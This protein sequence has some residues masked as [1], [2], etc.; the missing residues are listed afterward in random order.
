MERLKVHYHVFE[1]ADGREGWQ[2]TLSIHPTL[3]I[4][5]VAMPNVDGIEFS[6]KVKSDK[7]TSHIPLILLTAS[8]GD[9]QQLRGLL[10]GANDYLTKPFN[11]EI[12]NAKVNNLLALNRVSKGYYSKRINLVKPEVEIE[13]GN[14]KLLKDIAFFIE[15]N[16][17]NSLLSVENLSKHVGM[18]RGTLYSR[19]LELTGK[20]PVEYIRSVK[21]E[22]S[23]MLLEKSDLNISQIAY[24]VGFPNANYF[25]K[26]FKSQFNMLPSEYRNAKHL[27]NEV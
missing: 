11:F 24:S 22:K 25:T 8:T 17:N 12:L 6:Q 10:S 2:K 5:D 3:I 1:A 19:L 21:L 20:T 15:E 14:E 27:A 7:R 4:S 13:S 23:A 16:L 18:S 26:S 9:Q